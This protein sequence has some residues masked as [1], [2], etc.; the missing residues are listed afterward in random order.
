M[1]QQKITSFPNALRVGVI[2]SDE[3]QCFERKHRAVRKADSP[4]V[5]YVS[6]Q[7]I[8]AGWYRLT[9]IRTKIRPVSARHVNIGC[10]P[11]QHVCDAGDKIRNDQ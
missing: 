1:L 2:L 10:L 9:K 4:A 11:L 3:R 8:Q 6:I 7:R 5:K